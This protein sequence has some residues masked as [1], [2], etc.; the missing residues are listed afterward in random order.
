MPKPRLPELSVCQFSDETP[1]TYRYLLDHTIDE[2]VPS[3]ARKTVVFVLANPSVANQTQLDPTLRRCRAFTQRL[4]AHHMAI[5]NAFAFVSQDPKGM[6]EAEDPIGPLNDETIR[7][8]IAR[9]GVVATICG[10]GKIGAHRGRDKHLMA[11]LPGQLSALKLN[12]DGSPSHPLYLPANSPLL[13]F[14]FAVA[15]V[16]SVTAGAQTQSALDTVPQPA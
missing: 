4:G 13:P 15:P 16:Q 10:W 3:Y 5:V 8:T 6:Y 9:E 12:K 1:P 7:R 14:G 11:M 2:T